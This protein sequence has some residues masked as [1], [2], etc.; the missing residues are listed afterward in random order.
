VHE[1]LLRFGPLLQETFNRIADEA[2]LRALAHEAERRQRAL[3]LEREADAQLRVV[4]DLFAI[5]RPG[6]RAADASAFVWRY[7]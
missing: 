1:A 2:P 4:L 7:P 5:A 6:R 3:H